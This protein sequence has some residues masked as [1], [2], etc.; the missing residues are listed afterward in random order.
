M[1]KIVILGCENSHADIF[2]D[3]IR[4]REEYSDVEVVGVYSCEKEAMDKLVEKYGVKAMSSYDE[5]VDVV[6]GIII[7]ARH[8]DN[9]YKYAAPYIKK[10]IPMF[11]DKPITVDEDEAIRFMKEC[12]KNGVRVTG[13]SCCAHDVDAHALQREIESG[14]LGKVFSGFVCAP[15]EMN[16]E[17][18]GYF[19]YAQHLVGIMQTVFG[20][21]PKSVR[22]AKSEN[23][24]RALYCYDGFEVSA[25]YN[26]GCRKYH[27]TVVAPKGVSSRTL[28]ISI[29]CFV[30]EFDRFYRLLNG[31]EQI[32]SYSDFITAVHI[33]TATYRSML[34]GKEESITYSEI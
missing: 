15:I 31:E 14:A 6:D 27:A 21:R 10:G 26:D 23:G 16:S 28:G 17:H 32:D 11:I 4:D 13:G 9:H 20:L 5:A 18:G 25:H 2:L 12:K 24:L 3:F 1:K 29:D 33:M 19:F 7:T 34:S 22:S 8:G 30:E